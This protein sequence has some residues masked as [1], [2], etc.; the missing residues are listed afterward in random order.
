MEK[1][2]SR[3]FP[4]CTVCKTISI[5]H[6]G[7]GICFKCTERIRSR[8]RR[9]SDKNYLV[10]T[11]IYKIKSRGLKIS[12][13][14]YLNLWNSQEGCCF[15]C[16]KQLEMSGI[17]AQ[18]DHKIPGIHELKNMCIACRRC[19]GRKSNFTIKELLMFASKISGKEYVE[20]A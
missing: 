14:E 7:K 3:K 2:W 15:Y 6:K 17:E 13:D 20:V 19:N 8:K 10:H 11:K 1:Q 4:A 5:P 9:V 18:L 16:E 12:K